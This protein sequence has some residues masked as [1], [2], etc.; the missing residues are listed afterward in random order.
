MGSYVKYG[1]IT[2]DVIL[3]Q[4]VMHVYVVSFRSLITHHLER[5]LLP[6]LR[7]MEMKTHANLMI[8]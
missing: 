3:E 2:K 4:V 6:R 5:I 7:E 8:Q 1:L